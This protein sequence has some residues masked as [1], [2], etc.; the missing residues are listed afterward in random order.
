M[1]RVGI[2]GLRRGQAIGAAFESVNGV[3]I[4]AVCD[5]DTVRA[6]RYA[7]QHRIPQ[8]CA[9]YDRLLEMDLDIIAVCTPAPLHASHSIA[10]LE[11]GKHVLSK[12]PA[13]YS[14]EQCRE[15]IR[16][17]ERTGMQYMLAENCCFSDLTQTWAHWVSEGKIGKPVYAEAEY[18]H[19]C[20]SIMAEA[21][22]PTWRATLP[23]I[24]YCTHSLGPL[25]WILKDRCVSVSG[26]STGCNVAPE[27]GA[28]D[29]E[30]GLF[31]TVTG[32]IIKILCGFSVERHPSF[33]WYVLYGSQ[34]TLESRREPEGKH[35]AE[36]VDG[37]RMQ[38]H[39]IEASGQGSAEVRMGEGFVAASLANTSPPL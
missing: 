17:V 26:L 14:V 39:E 37:E 18:V 2:A 3:E 32:T 23:P 33:H 7:V 29:L 31:E 12:V 20:R 16:A 21:G 6:E 38:P 15:V 27:L 34:G 5:L 28:I 8:M 30:V 11:S 35:R 9:E 25:L 22:Q 24:C 4:R 36:L 10:A 1:L 13:A 19:D